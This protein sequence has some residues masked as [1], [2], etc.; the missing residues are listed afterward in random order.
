MYPERERDREITYIYIYR[1]RETLHI[2][3]SMMGLRS[4]TPLKHWQ[5]KIQVP[6][7][8]SL[9]GSLQGLSFMVIQGSRGSIGCMYLFRYAVKALGVQKHRKHRHLNS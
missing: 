6:T 9:K 4:P 1:E 5:A 3:V 8:G 7:K 2:V